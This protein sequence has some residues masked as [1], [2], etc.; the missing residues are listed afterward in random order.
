MK[1]CSLNSDFVKQLDRDILAFVNCGLENNDE[2]LFNQLALREFELQYHTIKPY[3]EYCRGKNISPE[4]I[5]SW[6]EIPAVA[7]FAFKKALDAAFPAQKAEDIYLASG[8][9]ELAR[10]RGKIYPDKGAKEIM[11]TANSLLEKAYLFSD[12][13]RMKML[14]MVPPP[15][16][17]PG[18][19]M[20]SGSQQMVRRFGMSDSRFLIN[21]HGLNL[22]TLIAALKEAERSKQPIAL[23]VPTM[24][25]DYFFDACKK[26][27]LRFNLPYGSRICDSGGYMGRYVRCSKEE[28]LKKCSDMLGMDERF[29][30]NALW[31][32]ESSTVYF[33]NV[34]RNSLAGFK[35]KR[36]KEVPPWSRIIVV[37]PRDFRRLPKG[38]IGLLRHYDLTNRAMAFCVQTDKMGCE[39]EDGF[40]VV[41]K[42]NQDMNS[43]D[44]ERLPR[45]PGGRIVSSV[46]DTFLAWKFSKTG[47]IY[48]SL[49]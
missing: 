8:V 23:V 21:F 22:K 17:A 37:D 46:M 20:A 39:T 47:K 49:K 5:T 28:Y 24:I 12:V 29:C 13:E 43:P 2:E 9:V 38:E 32:C 34:L 27:G 26:E 33:D 40:E 31:I 1:D 7:S 16:M 4:G 41:G 14:L 25:F 35:R 45:H 15:A 48:S 3:R 44:I 10:K 30:V 11:N 42:W 18:M 6:R 36:C 19:V